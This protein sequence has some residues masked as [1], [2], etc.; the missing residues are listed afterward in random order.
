[1]FTFCFYVIDKS[2]TIL[3]FSTKY[4]QR[5]VDMSVPMHERLRA[6]LCQLGMNV[7]TLAR[8]AHV[9]RSFV[10]DILRGKSQVPNLEKLTRIAAVVKVDLEWL[11]S[12]KGRVDGDDP[13]YRRVP[14]RL[15]RDP[16][17]PMRAH[18]WA[19]AQSLKMKIGL[20]G[21]ST[22]AAPGSETA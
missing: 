11:L 13:Y 1:M 3:F 4:K 19:V 16:I 12:G 10:Y 17:R 22:S 8:E 2:I 14:Q 9:N 20:G 21:I 18:R 15:R 7:A 6:R 5:N